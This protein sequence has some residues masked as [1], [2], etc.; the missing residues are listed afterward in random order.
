MLLL[1][2]ED[3]NRHAALQRMEVVIEEQRAADRACVA[4]LTASDKPDLV[5]RGCLDERALRR[6]RF[7]GLLT[8]VLSPRPG[9]VPPFP[10]IPDAIDGTSIYKDGFEL[11]KDKGCAKCH[12]VDGTRLVGGSLRGLLGS[13]LTHTDDSSALVDDA[14]VR[15]AILFPQRRVTKGYLPVMPSYQ[16]RIKDADIALL[17]GWMRQLDRGS[18]PP[19]P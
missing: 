16:G 6:E 1:A 9:E 5:V 12:T 10:P 17:L 13:T 14:Y 19:A 18:A 7:D 11:F 4:A 8:M 3:R 2:C 15:E